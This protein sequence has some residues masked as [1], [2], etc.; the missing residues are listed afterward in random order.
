MAFISDRVG[1]AAPAWLR[2]RE[3]DTALIFG[4]TGLAL[5]AGVV[6]TIAPASLALMLIADNWVL[7]FPH[8][9]S[10]FARIAPDRESLKRHRFLVF[11]LPVIVLAATTAL[12]LGIGI[13]IVATIY[14]YWQWYH[15]M[16]QS[17]G[18]AQLYR[19]KAGG[20]VR[21]NPL[22][23]EAMFALVPVWGLL[24]RLTTA[25]THFLY[26]SL[27]IVVP[28]VPVALAN[29]VGAIACAGLAWW[30][31]CRVREAIQA[32]LALTYTLFS[33]SH[34]LIFIVGYIVMD[35][36][37]G[38]W[39]VTNIW[40]TS[41]YLM[42]VWMFNENVVAKGA[43]KGWFWSL[44][45][46]NRAPLYFAACLLSA[47]AIYIPIGSPMLWGSGGIVFALI[48]SQTLNFNHFITDAIIWRSRRKPVGAPV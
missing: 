47:L 36:V 21:E 42:L 25:P 40:H 8:L 31:I 13:A 35:D 45:R 18:V 20:A 48:A 9:M 10:T 32:E 38:G 41:Q 16:R 34:Y 37:S 30:A 2:G 23:A 24:H 33:A 28:H 44:T 14:F 26:P 12:A 17:W 4:L 5:S 43:P 39:I 7:G 3:F 1:I 15:T 22:F 27:P 6:V 11:G 19:R 29:G 46:G